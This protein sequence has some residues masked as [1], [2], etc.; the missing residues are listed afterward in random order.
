M[1]LVLDTNAALDLLH[2]HDARCAGLRDAIA[3]GRATVH[4]NAACRAEFLRVLRYPALALDPARI[5]ALEAAYDA[6]CLRV[7]TAR[8]GALPRCRDRDDQ[9]FLEL[10]RDARADALL[11]RDAELLRLARRAQRDA[12]F[13]VSVPEALDFG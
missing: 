10:A 3:R 12:G 7:D 1:R 11:T 13:T 2:F 6:L 9:A 5:G 8:D 4:T